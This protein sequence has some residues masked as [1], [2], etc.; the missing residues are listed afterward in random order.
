MLRKELFLLLF[1][2]LGVFV[3]PCGGCAESA[4][5]TE[6]SVPYQEFLIQEAEW[7]QI[8]RYTNMN[9][10]ASVN[11]ETLAEYKAWWEAKAEHQSITIPDMELLQDFACE[12][13]RTLFEECETSNFL[14]S[15]VSLWFCLNTLADLTD[16]NS[17]KQILQVIGQQTDEAR[18]AQVD[19]AFRSLYWND[20]VSICI[21]A[22][23][24]WLN[25]ST[26]ISESL[27]NQLAT[28][29]NA[30]F[31]GEMGEASYNEA[32][33]AWL[34][35][36][37]RG[38]LKDCVSDLR[39]S[40][41][42]ALAI[43]STLYLKN[44]WLSRFN[45]GRTFPDVFYSDSGEVTTDF[46]HASDRGAVYTGNGFTAAIMDFEDG[47]GVTFILPDVGK[48]PED[49]LKDDEAFRFLFSGKKWD[50]A[51]SGTINLS[52]PKID[53]M[54]SLPLQ[55][56]LGKMGIS[57]VFDPEKAS[58]SSEVSTD[59]PISLSVLQQHARL[60]LNEEGVEAAAITI[61]ADGTSLRQSEEKIDFAL[62]R[63]FLYAVMSE[64]GIP[65]FIGAYHTP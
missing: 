47:G 38:L 2:T 9:D 65:L 48:S 24:V 58:F 12:S 19:A 50:R 41:N 55:S 14:Y 23:S 46:M 34:N 60:I 44:G 64:Q 17:Q 13:T 15:P 33:Q 6:H 18:N 52:V 29:H 5:E 25:K 61:S 21:P 20:D 26:E 42:D 62:N 59:S 56:V 37:T 51:Q 11:E 43:C 27:L 4:R 22:M 40:P 57:D 32:L 36:E 10:H 39:L 28:V 54:A 30:V 63:P 53:C 31:K 16:G 49:L 3:F 45:K 35:A 1:L 8:P 7:P